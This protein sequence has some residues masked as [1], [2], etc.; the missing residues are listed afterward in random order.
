MPFTNH[1]HLTLINCSVCCKLSNPNGPSASCQTSRWTVLSVKNTCCSTV[2]D[3][4]ST[5]DINTI[6]CSSQWIHQPTSYIPHFDRSVL[7][8]CLYIKTPRHFTKESLTHTF[9]YYPGFFVEP[10]GQPLRKVAKRCISSR[11]TAEYEGG[12][13]R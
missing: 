7:A 6:S 3:R 4:S 5:I 2:R 13:Q 11:V 9:L 12:H 1:S 10:R 8:L